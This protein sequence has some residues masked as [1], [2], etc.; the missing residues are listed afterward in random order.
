M[1]L[2]Q[3]NVMHQLQLV[4][5]WDEH[6]MQPIQAQSQLLLLLFLPRVHLLQEVCCNSKTSSAFFLVLHYLNTDILQQNRSWT[7]C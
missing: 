2:I 1:T 7:G 4:L 3:K 6:K 5:I